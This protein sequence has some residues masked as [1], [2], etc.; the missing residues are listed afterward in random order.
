MTS[1]PVRPVRLSASHRWG[2]ET[3][4]PNNVNASSCSPG[5]AGAEWLAGGRRHTT[6]QKV[7][8]E[9]QEITPRLGRL[10]STQRTF[11]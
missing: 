2:S 4:K 8:A 7:P 3:R 5:Q 11:Q 10:V 6:G 1:G 9:T